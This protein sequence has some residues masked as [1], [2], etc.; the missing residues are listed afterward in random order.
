MC[1]GLNIPSGFGALYV[2]SF[3]YFRQGPRK[4]YAT[5]NNIASYEIA[6]PRMVK[7]MYVVF[8]GPSLVAVVAI[9]QD[10]KCLV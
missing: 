1:N 9:T 3:I 10:K 7:Y 4:L 6:V 8:N 2:H 5:I